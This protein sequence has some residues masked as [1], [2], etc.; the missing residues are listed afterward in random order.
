MESLNLPSRGEKL[1]LGREVYDGLAREVAAMDVAGL[2]ALVLAPA[3][4]VASD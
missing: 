1:L 2:C 4:A 3:S